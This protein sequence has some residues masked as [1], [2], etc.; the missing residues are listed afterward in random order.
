MFVVEYTEQSELVGKCARNK[1]WKHYTTKFNKL[2]F[3]ND[4]VSLK[5]ACKREEKVELEL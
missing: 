4:L 2:G 1:K 5:F 3:D